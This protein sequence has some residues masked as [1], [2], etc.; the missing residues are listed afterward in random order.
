MYLEG[1]L[2]SDNKGK[3]LISKLSTKF[4]NNNSENNVEWGIKII[5]FTFKLTKKPP[6]HQ[7]RI[8]TYE[9]NKLIVYTMIEGIIYI[10]VGT[11][12]S[13]FGCKL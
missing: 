4:K 12:L 11:E 5:T 6:E 3:I 9:D 1:I 2:I 10:V 8:V 13:E 7:Y